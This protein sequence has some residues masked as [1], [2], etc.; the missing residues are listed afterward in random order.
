MMSFYLFES[1][2]LILT[3]QQIEIFACLQGSQAHALLF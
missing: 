2:L 1:F 3:T